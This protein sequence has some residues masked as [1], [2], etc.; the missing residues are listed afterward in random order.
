MRNLFFLVLALPLL[1][2]A[3]QDAQSSLLY[4]V[5]PHTNPSFI[6]NDYKLNVGADHRRQW[7]GLDGAP[8]TTWGFASYEFNRIH[9]AFGLSYSHNQLGLF[10]IHDARF[11]YAYRITI[12]EL[13]H[14]IPSIY[15][16]TQHITLDGTGLNP[17]QQGD[18]NIISTVQSD[19]VFDMGF[20]LAYR[21]RELVLGLSLLHING[22]TAEFQQFNARSTYTLARHVYFAGRYD[23]HFGEL[24]RLMPKTLLKSDMA[25]V[26]FDVGVWVGFDNLSGAFKR[27]NLGAAYRIDDAVVVSSELIFKWFTLGYAYD[28]T[29]SRL[30]DFSNGSHEGY[31][32][33]HLFKRPGENE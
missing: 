33:V 31:L 13:H 12:N 16:G 15:F 3:Q 5:N 27:V 25:S 2:Y 20:G 28:I 17:I 21:F 10:K 1:S 23:H 11:N 18:P 7:T 32:R 8:I 24:M 19:M 6:V 4:E 22:A 29:T 26:Q 14:L 9:S 30:K